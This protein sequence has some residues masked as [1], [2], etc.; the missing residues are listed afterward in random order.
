M[1]ESQMNYIGPSMNPTLKTG[2]GMIVVP[3]EDKKIRKGDVVVFRHPENDHHVVH[4]VVSL[5][6]QKVKTKGDNNKLVDT[7]ELIS[8][9]IIGRVVFVKRNNKNTVIRGGRKGNLL[10]SAYSKIKWIDTTLSKIMSPVYYKLIGLGIFKKCLRFFPNVR[11]ISFKKSLGEELHL[12]MGTRVV[13]R[14]LSGTQFWQI[15][16]PFRLFIDET[17]LPK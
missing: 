6:S 3:Y 4:R 12:L 13:G 7:W 10:A 1:A 5:N 14:R 2:D 11:F 8:D 16:R 9:D 17:S 15:A